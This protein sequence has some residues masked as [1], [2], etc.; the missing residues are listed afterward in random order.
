MSL[1]GFFIKLGIGLSFTIGTIIGI[2]SPLW[3]ARLIG[4]LC[5]WLGAILIDVY[6]K[7]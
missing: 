6:K 4:F 5:Y 1:K 7:L 3:Y 2:G